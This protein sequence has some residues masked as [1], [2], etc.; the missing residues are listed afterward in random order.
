MG[1]ALREK[2]ACKGFLWR[3]TG[4]SK[5]EQFNEQPVIKVCCS[6]AEKIAFVSIADAAR[7]A[8]ISAPAL[9]QRIITQVHLGDY[10]WVFDKKSTHYTF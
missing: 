6:T 10:H 4:I 2:R 8:K 5:E 3:Y 1:I 7:D 9:R